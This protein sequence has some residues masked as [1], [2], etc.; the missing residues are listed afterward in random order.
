[1]VTFLDFTSKIWNTLCQLCQCGEHFKLLLNY[2]L[3]AT[4]TPTPTHKSNRNR[5]VMEEPVYNS[6][7]FDQTSYG[8]ILCVTE[9]PGQPATVVCINEKGHI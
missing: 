9:L 7:D 8:Y 4:Q 6:Q 1:M 2:K 3:L 5:M